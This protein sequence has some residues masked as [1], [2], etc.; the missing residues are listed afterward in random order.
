MGEKHRRFIPPILLCQSV[1]LSLSK[2]FAL[3]LRSPLFS[4]ARGDARAK[5]LNWLLNEN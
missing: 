1:I 5:R 2:D 4:R 3:F